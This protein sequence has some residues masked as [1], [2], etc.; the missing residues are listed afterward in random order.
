MKNLQPNEV[1]LTF[2]ASVITYKWKYAEK[3]MMAAILNGKI[4]TNN[5]H[6]L[7]TT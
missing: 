3:V 5:N 2:T 1:D 6:L 4:D 7:L